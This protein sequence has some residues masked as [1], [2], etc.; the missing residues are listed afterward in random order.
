MNYSMIE[1]SEQEEVRFRIIRKN[2]LI[3]SDIL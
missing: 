1:W 2:V 3:I